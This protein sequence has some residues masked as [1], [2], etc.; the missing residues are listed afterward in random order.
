MD[1]IPVG[2]PTKPKKRNHYTCELK[3]H[4]LALLEDGL[5]PAQVAKQT[6]VRESNIYRWR[7]EFMAQSVAAMDELQRELKR[8]RQE[9]T[10]LKNR[11][12]ALQQAPA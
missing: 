3:Q 6:G 2:L 5:T 12:K 11:L 4:T 9:N 1:A 7:R 8:L 10:A